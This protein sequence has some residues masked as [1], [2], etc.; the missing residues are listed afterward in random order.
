MLT[1]NLIRVRF[2]RDRIVPQFIKADDAN[3]LQVAETLLDLFRAHQ[4][5]SR[6]ELQEEI[7]EF[8][9]GF[10][11]P[12]VP[13]GLAKLLEDRCTF[14]VQ[15]DHPPEELREK[16][17]SLA[18]HARRRKIG[19]C[20]DRNQV[21]NEASA[22]LGLEA[23]LIDAG[24]FADLKSEQRLVE[25]NDISA[26][27]LLQRYNVALVQAILLRA[28]RVTVH[29]R[30]ES[31][32]RYRQLFRRMKFHRLLCEIDSAGPGAYT[33]RLDGP[34]SLFSATQK[35]GL[36]LALF[37]PTLLLCAS[38]ELEA[39]LLW[40]PERK[41]RKFHLTHK[42]GLVSHAQDAGSYT[43]PELVMFADLFRKKI[44]T[45]DLQPDPEIV[46]LARGFWVPDFVLVHRSTGRSLYLEILGY[47]RRSSVE[48]QL[49]MLREQI[50]EPFLL[51]LSEQLHIEEE[52]LEDLPAGVI[53][54]RQMPL[55][56]AI[57]KKAE[58]WL[59]QNS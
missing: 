56:D 19:D 32:G 18:A 14:E 13:K 31:V 58:Q 6:G 11:Q 17:F 57:V 9:S 59:E 39:D 24:L 44:T 38:F 36:Q 27:R 29:L 47:W 22:Q 4:G 8:F 28:T 41:P 7:D 50:R 53:A 35:Y 15:A 54:F 20:F 37:L 21:L 49:Q 42:D 12:L 48:R 2:A 40:G 10:P 25:F 30:G 45:W 5:D 33:L 3:L 16:V 43:P 26:E 52:S 34:L 51:A 1:S 23:G 46:P 55:P